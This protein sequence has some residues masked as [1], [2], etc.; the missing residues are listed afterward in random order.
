MV[1]TSNSDR[2]HGH[3]EE[4]RGVARFSASVEPELLHEFDEMTERL[5][6]NRSTAIVAAMR[7]F[8]VDRVWE[9][10][11]GEVVGAITL[12]YDHH[13]GDVTEALTEIQHDYPHEIISTTHIHLDHD[14]CLEI[15]A[16]QGGS[17]RIKSLAE[18]LS[19]CHGV[20]QVKVSILKN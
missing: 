17:K 20:K 2:G 13:R 19:T 6:Y 8:L 15:V 11:I 7:N 16:V 9:G 14:N 4:K 18:R 12:V 10:E 5:G 1:I 3:D